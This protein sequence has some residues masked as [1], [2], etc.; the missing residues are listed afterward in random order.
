MLWFFVVILLTRS[1]I[2][3]HT[4]W[5]RSMST[6]DWSLMP[7]KYYCP[8]FVYY[9]CD[10]CYCNS[11]NNLSFMF[12]TL[13]WKLFLIVCYM[14]VL[15]SINLHAYL[16]DVICGFF[17]LTNSSL[18]ARPSMSSVKRNIV[19]FSWKYRKL[20]CFATCKLKQI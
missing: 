20:K 19:N 18:S 16:N 17:K 15:F 3:K 1:K 12:L 14:F 11:W 7:D 9:I 5:F 13:N 4:E 6:I 8:N 10:S 2:R